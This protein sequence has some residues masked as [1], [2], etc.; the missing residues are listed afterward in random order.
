VDILAEQPYTR[1]Q[2]YLDGTGPKGLHYYWHTG[3]LSGLG[4]GMLAAR[5]EPAVDCPIPAAQPSI[6]R[7][8]GALNDRAE[9][10]GAVGNRDARYVIGVNGMWPPGEPPA[11]GYRQ[12][13]RG[14]WQQ[15]HRGACGIESWYRLSP[16]EPRWPSSAKR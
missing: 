1:L 16:G 12:W 8:G 2:S 5:R 9:D 3:Y 11:D 13:V 10:D 6:L 4:D 7:I 14:A 15:R